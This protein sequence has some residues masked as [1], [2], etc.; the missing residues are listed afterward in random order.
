M[1]C[2][3][4]DDEWASEELRDTVEKC[5]GPDNDEDETRCVTGV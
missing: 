5:T 2:L 1:G 4:T 3:M